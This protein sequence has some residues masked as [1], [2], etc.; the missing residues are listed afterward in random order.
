MTSITDKD[1]IKSFNIETVSHKTSL[2]TISKLQWEIKI[3]VT[4]E[5]LSLDTMCYIFMYMF[6][7]IDL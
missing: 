6:F 1:I 3:K 7:P 5:A 4:K 2:I